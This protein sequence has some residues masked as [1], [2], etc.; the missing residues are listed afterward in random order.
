MSMG[1][2]V[3]IAIFFGMSVFM[4]MAMAGAGVKNIEHRRQP[5]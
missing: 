5:D 4:A 3:P 2:L 1:I